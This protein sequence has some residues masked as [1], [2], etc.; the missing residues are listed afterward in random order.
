MIQPNP[1][2]EL[3]FLII[4][5]GPAGIQM[6][7]FMKKAG[8]DHLVLE[9]H[10]R[11]GT[12]LEKYPRHG[13]MISINKVYTGYTQRAA[14]LRYDWNSLL[15]DDDDVALAKY[16]K[17]Y[18]PKTE[19][20]ARYTQDF[21][22]RYDL[23]IQF[24]TRVESVNK[25]GD[26][27]EGYLVRDQ[28]GMT[29]HARCLI[30][31]VGVQKP[32]LPNIPGIELTE[33]YSDMSIDP[34]EFADQRVLILGKG[35]SAFETANHLIAATRVTHLCSPSPIKM[36]W[37]THFFGHLRAVN[38]DF[39]DTYILKGQN[40]VLD[41]EVESIEKVDGEYRV[42]IRFTHAEDQRATMAYDRVLCCTG[43]RWD[44]SFFD[45]DCQPDMACEDRLPAM[46]SAWESTNLPGVFYVGTIMQIRDLKKTMSSVLHGFRF[47]TACL[48]NLLS[49]RYLEKPW[50]CDC[51]AA[52][53]HLI[54]EKITHQVSSAAGLMHQPGFLG[55]CLVIDD[56][57]G[58]AKYFENIAVDYIQESDFAK[59]P[60]YYIITMEY[61]E[62]DGDIFS[63]DR[64]PD[65]AKAYD[66]AYLHPR[67]RRMCRGQ[68]LAEHHIS[69]SLENDWRIGEHP[70]ERPLIRAIGFKGLDDPSQ[71]QQTH[72]KQLLAFLDQQLAV[73]S[74]AIEPC[75]CGNGDACQCQRSVATPITTNQSVGNS[76]PISRNG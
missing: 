14:Q 68:M 55:D 63:K 25:A 46:T 54:A 56:E 52:D 43:F 50:P 28:H 47:N 36:A 42:E 37:Q 17:D 24:N 41:A 51:F 11:P 60:H 71:Y 53:S 7:Y 30:V 65:A 19:D 57:T 66:D 23:E 75:D 64:D 16:S 10:D 22:K 27:D 45:D 44:P 8:Y 34:E 31:A 73:G 59:N 62:F 2:R 6:S 33:N 61:G 18:F 58:Q 3:D 26:G 49:Q 74:P 40:S 9:A 12:F 76:C 20:Y 38:N 39:L 29:Y 70:G 32:Y 15:C 69:E 21:V 48:F 67:I 72:R 5:A 13:Q 4:G 35:N 1:K